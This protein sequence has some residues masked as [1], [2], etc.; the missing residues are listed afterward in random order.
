LDLLLP[1]LAK[2][3][4]NLQAFALKHKDLPTLGYFIILALKDGPSLTYTIEQIHAF[5]GRPAHHVRI[6][7]SIHFSVIAD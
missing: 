7:N 3:I 5:P 1:K 4:Q 2:V 6:I